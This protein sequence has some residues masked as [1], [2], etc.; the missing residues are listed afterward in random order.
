M[1]RPV[2]VLG[3]L[4]TLSALSASFA[5][6][7]WASTCAGMELDMPADNMAGME[8]AGIDMGSMMMDEPSDDLQDPAAPSDTDLPGSKGSPDDGCPLTAAAGSCFQ[9]SLPA[10]RL[11]VDLAPAIV[12]NGRTVCAASGDLLFVSPLLRPPR[13]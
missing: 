9:I 1:R 4:A 11:A 7:V 13:V 12:L 2:R 8:M 5:E 3:A 10:P 6:G